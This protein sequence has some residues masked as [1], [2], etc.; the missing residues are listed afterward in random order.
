[1][2]EKRH[3]RERLERWI[4]SVKQKLEKSEQM[5]AQ[6]QRRIIELEQERAATDTSSSS[7]QQ[8]SS[9]ARIKMTWREGEKAPCRMSTMYNVTHP[10]G[11][12]LQKAL[13][14]R[15]PLSTT[16]APHSY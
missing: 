11:V 16:S 9:L 12:N 1:M 15:C 4:G 7:K 3:D 5:I 13:P 2:R 14:T 8:S 6:F 10:P